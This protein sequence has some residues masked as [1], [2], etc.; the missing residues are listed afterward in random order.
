MMECE[1]YL[2]PVLR[3]MSSPLQGSLIYLT[4]EN[5]RIACS[6]ASSSEALST[7]I[8]SKSRSVDSSKDLTHSVIACGLFLV[9]ITT[10]KLSLLQVL[11]PEKGT[12]LFNSFS[13]FSSF[14][15]I[16]Y[17]LHSELFTLLFPDK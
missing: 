9:Q 3:A 8:N 2:A 7:T 10:D 13:S 5:L 12:I 1:A 4:S 16:I 11:P 6:V 14:P 15:S 17:L